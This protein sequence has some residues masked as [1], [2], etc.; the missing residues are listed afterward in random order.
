MGGSWE[1]PLW[2]VFILL[3]VSHSLSAF[4]LSVS[5]RRLLIDFVIKR[6]GSEQS[7]ILNPFDVRTKLY[8]RRILPRRI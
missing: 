7:R 8:A 6:F 1:I 3:L 2:G 5:E 4:T